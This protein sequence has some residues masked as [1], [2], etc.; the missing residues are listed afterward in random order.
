M[1]NAAVDMISPIV[2]R[3]LFV[4]RG[5][6]LYRKNDKFRSLIAIVQGT[7][8]MSVRYDQDQEQ[9]LGFRIIGDVVGLSG[10]AGGH[11]LSDAQ[12]LENSHICEIPFETLEQFALSVPKIQHQI[13]QLLSKELVSCQY[14]SISLGKKNAEQ[15]L[16]SF[17][18]NLSH[19]YNR[20]GYSA[21][22]FIL[23]MTR[24]DIANYLGLTKETVSRLFNKFKEKCILFTQKKHIQITNT[25]ILRKISN[26]QDAI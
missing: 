1:G 5:E 21:D 25:D 12:I 7:V 2:K 16:A 15:R 4:R 18:L 8:K 10:L 26:N 14:Q 3:H 11:Y 9:I 19:R 17:L 13:M 23:A 24:N 22:Y 6:F 20:Q